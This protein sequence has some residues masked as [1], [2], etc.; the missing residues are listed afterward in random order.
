MSR[1]FPHSKQ[2]SKSLQPP[3]G[4][5]TVQFG[6][7]TIP[8]VS[9]R[10]HKLWTQSCKSALWVLLIELAGAAHR[11]QESSLRP[12]L[13]IYYKRVH[14]RNSQVEE[15]PRARWVGKGTDLLCP[16]QACHPPKHLCVFTNPEAPRTPPFWVFMEASLHTQQR[17]VESNAMVFPVAFF[18]YRCES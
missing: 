12:R 11:T 17:P 7:D 5:P 8:G 1:C 4:C 9:V 6:S 2:F 15:M 3:A 13:L 10:S 16:P 14:L 18:M